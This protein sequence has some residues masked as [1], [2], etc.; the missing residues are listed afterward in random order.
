MAHPYG[1][2]SARSRGFRRARAIAVVALLAACVWSLTVQTAMAAPFVDGINSTLEQEVGWSSDAGKTT[3][4]RYVPSTAY[5]LKRIELPF[6]PWSS[7]PR[8]FPQPVGT[9]SVVLSVWQ[10]SGGKPVGPPLRQTTIPLFEGFPVGGST[11]G[12]FGGDLSSSLALTAGTPYWLA[13]SSDQETYGH[14]A[15]LGTGT[16]VAEWSDSNNDGTF[17]TDPGAWLA[18]IFKLFGETAPPPVASVPASSEWAF[19]LLAFA[20]MGTTAFAVRRRRAG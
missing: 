11:P 10:D 6:A 19:A 1:A 16:A 2:A 12:F 14:F 7:A 20:A 9:G 3:A 18:P 17:E 15:P 13:F 5:A 8:M 4:F